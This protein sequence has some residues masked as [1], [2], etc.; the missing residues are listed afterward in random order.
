MVSVTRK[1]LLCC[2]LLFSGSD[3]ICIPW[4][5][6]QKQLLAMLSPAD[7]VHALITTVNHL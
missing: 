5:F 1:M 2:V 7:P 4:V 3:L 6:V